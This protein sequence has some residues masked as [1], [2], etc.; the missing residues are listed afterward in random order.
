MLFQPWCFAFSIPFKYD[1][2]TT[3]EFFR[4]TSIW[5]KNR[6]ISF[7]FF[8]GNVLDS[9]DGR[10]ISNN[11]IYVDFGVI[12]YKCSCSFNFAFNPQL[13]YLPSINPGFD[14]CGTAIQI[15][16]MNNNIFSIQCMSSVPPIVSSSQF[17]TVELTCGY[18]RDDNYCKYTGYC[19][20]VFSNGR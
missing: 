10:V 9:C 7:V 4:K 15:K 11:N 8:L 16:E 14:D 2:T 12:K 13:F 18:P 19:L 6:I 17:T 1:T 20:R 5:N 3:N